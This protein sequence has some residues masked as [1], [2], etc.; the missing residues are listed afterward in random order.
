MASGS[1]SGSTSQGEPRVVPPKQWPKGGPRVV[2]P[3]KEPHAA[4]AGPSPKLE[5]PSRAERLGNQFATA[6]HKR[7]GKNRPSK[8]RYFQGAWATKQKPERESPLAPEL[9]P[10]NRPILPVHILSMNIAT[11]YLQKA[12]VAPF[13]SINCGSYSMVRCMKLLEDAGVIF[14]PTIG[15]QASR[16]LSITDSNA[17]V[18]RTFNEKIMARLR[19]ELK[20]AMSRLLSMKYIYI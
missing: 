7:G 3:P 13:M 1:G 19:D 4:E 9:P 14:S 17:R 10:Y 20:A 6:R 12:E 11:S 18:L 8:S 16:E 2:A 15:L 5:G